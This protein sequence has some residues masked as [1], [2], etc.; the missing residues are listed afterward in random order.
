MN[1]PP[2][3]QPPYVTLGGEAPVLALAARF[4]DIMDAK[5]P[6]LAAVHELDEAGK[7]SARTRANFASFL[8][9]WLG[10]PQTYLQTHGHPRLRMRHHRVRIDLAQRDAWLACMG[11]AMDGGKISGD[12]R[13][14]LDQRFAEVADFLRNV[15]EEP[16]VPQKPS[17]KIVE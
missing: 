17:L 11:E 4:Y 6:Q 9:M 13:R 14:F 7:V 16:S 5:Y 3:N 12:I 10:G 2:D 8:V 1:R 15:A